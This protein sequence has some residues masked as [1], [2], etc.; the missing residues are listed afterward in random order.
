ML[1]SRCFPQKQDQ[2][3]GEL[4]WWIW[5]HLHVDT[6]NELMPTCLYRVWRFW[7]FT[8]LHVKSEGFVGDL[9]NS[10]LSSFLPPPLFSTFARLMLTQTNTVSHTSRW[11]AGLLPVVWCCPLLTVDRKQNMWCSGCDGWLRRWRSAWRSGSSVRL[12]S[13][14]TERRGKRAGYSQTQFTV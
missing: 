10:T 4:P 1:T 6:V 11:V 5:G 7:T 3:C 9:L 2:T 14:F 12:H 8:V 13:A